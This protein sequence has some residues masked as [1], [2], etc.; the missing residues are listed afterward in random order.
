MYSLL[1]GFAFG[2]PKA[3]HDPSGK[4]YAAVAEML[5]RVDEKN[6]QVGARMASCFNK[7]KT[8]TPALRAMQVEQVRGILAASPSKNTKEILGLTLKS[9]GE[10]APAAAAAAG[11]QE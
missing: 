1:G 6:A 9:V 10:E 11:G 3:F 7:A 4:G 8:V 5:K 2:N